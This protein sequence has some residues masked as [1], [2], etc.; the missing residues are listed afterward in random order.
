MAENPTE[1]VKREGNAS[2]TPRGLLSRIFGRQPEASSVPAGVRV[3]AVG[4]IHGRLDLLGALQEKIARDGE[5]ATDKRIIVYLGDYIDRGADSKGVIERLLAQPPEGFSA[6]HLKGNHDQSLLDFLEEPAHYRMWKDY[7]ARETLLSYGV[8]PPRGEGDSALKKAS[9]DLAL[10]L[11][12]AHLEFIR[13][14]ELSVTIGDYFFVHAGV[15]PG[16][17]LSKQSPQD[18]MWI[19]EEFL[20]SSSDFGKVVVHGHSPSPMPVKRANRIGVDTGAYAT[21]RLSCV[22]LEGASCRFLQTGT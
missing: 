1:P 18:L 21:G 2:S 14:L 3:Y 10:A 22:V 6:R 12:E 15:R 8:M 9:E 20:T 5:T 16:L 11:P 19:R 7:G 4:D 13:G 17:P